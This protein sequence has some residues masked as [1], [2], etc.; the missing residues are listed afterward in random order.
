[1]E[2]RCWKTVHVLAGSIIEAVLVDYLI[3]TRDPVKS[4]RHAS[5]KDPMQMM[6]GELI[7]VCKDEGIL[8]LRSAELSTVVKDYRNLIHPGRVVRL[9]ETVDEQGAKVAEALVEMIVKDVEST[10]RQKY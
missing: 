7:V 4:S 8:S 5:Q 1:M 9:Q 3:A 6:L 10:K 2:N